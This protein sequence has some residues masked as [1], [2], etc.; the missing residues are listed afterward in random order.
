MC[1]SCGPRP[2]AELDQVVAVDR[3]VAQPVRARQLPLDH[4]AKAREPLDLLHGRRLA[5]AAALAE[6]VGLL[7]VDEVERELVAVAT[8]G[9]VAPAA[10][11][12]SPG[13]NMWRRTIRDDALPEPRRIPKPE[14]RRRREVRADLVVAVGGEAGLRVVVEATV[15]PAPA[16]DRLAEVVEERRE[17]HGE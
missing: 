10:R 17:P 7:V 16:D 3:E 6:Q 15:V 5:V 8:R 9:S 12:P 14:Q 11:R 4:R 1:P 2:E 13:W